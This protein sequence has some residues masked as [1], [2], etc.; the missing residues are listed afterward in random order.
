MG[1]GFPLGVTLWSSSVPMQESGVHNYMK[2]GYLN[3]RTTE[4]G[5]GFLGRQLARRVV[6]EIC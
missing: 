6:L 5:L 2:I 1:N 4:F 3:L